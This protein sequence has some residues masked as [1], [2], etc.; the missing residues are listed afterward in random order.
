MKGLDLKRGSNL[1]TSGLLNRGG[2][3]A[4]DLAVGKD[5]VEWGRVKM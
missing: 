1:G 2:K 3:Q 4:V 5:P